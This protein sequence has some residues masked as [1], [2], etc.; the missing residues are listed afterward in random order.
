MQVGCCQ[1]RSVSDDGRIACH[2]IVTGDNEVS[3]QI[4]YHCPARACNCQHLR[5]SLD[6]VALTPI[7]VRWPSGRVE[8]W[9]SQ[10]PRVSFLR[11][12]CATRTTPITSPADCQT[13]SMRLGWSVEIPEQ[14]AVR[15]VP[16]ALGDNVLPFIRPLRK[17]PTVPCTSS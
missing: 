2:K 6:K 17:E 5:F 16:L 14:P 10:P 9:D 11:S 4:C 3:P 8:V 7:T 12:A 15:Q 1:Y 13:C